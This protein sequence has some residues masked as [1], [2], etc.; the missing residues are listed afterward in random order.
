TSQLRTPPIIHAHAIPVSSFHS[1]IFLLHFILLL[2]TAL[3]LKQVPHDFLFDVFWTTPFSVAPYRYKQEVLTNCQLPTRL[4]R[5]CEGFLLR[6]H[7]H[8]A[9]KCRIHH[10]SSSNDRFFTFAMRFYWNIALFGLVLLA[11]LRATDGL[12]TVVRPNNGSFVTISTV[13]SECT[14]CEV[15]GVNATE[16]T[17][18]Q[19]RSLTP[20]QEVKLQFKCSKPIEQAF[21]VAITHTIDC[22]K[23]SCSPVSAA[24]QDLLSDLPRV[25]N[26]ELTAP[27]KTSVRLDPQGKG[28]SKT[29]KP[30][31]DG[32]LLSLSQSKSGPEELFC[33]GGPIE[34]LEVTNGA[35]VQL[36]VDP[37]TTVEPVAFTAV[38]LKGRTMEVSVGPRREVV[39]TRKPSDPECDVCTGG[40][41][42][43]TE[44]TITNADKVQLE[45]SC[46]KPQDVYTVKITENIEC[47][48]SSCTP[49]A[50]EIDL[51]LFKGFKQTLTWDISL[52]PKTVLTLDFPE[53][54]LEETSGS[55]PDGFQYFISSSKSDGTPIKSSYCRGTSLSSLYQSGQT[56]IILEVS[57][58]QDLPLTLFR[59]NAAKRGSR[60]LTVTTDPDTKVT[61]RRDPHGLDCDVCV[62]KDS[63]Q[64]CT[65]K[66][67]LRDPRNVTV[68]FSCKT[69]Q[70]YFTVEIIRDVDCAKTSCSSDI[71]QTEYSMFP[72]FNRTFI[73]DLKVVPTQAFQLNFPEPGMRQIPNKHS[74][75]DEH[76]Y[77]VVTYLR[78][79]PATIGTFCKG[80]AVSSVLVRYKGRMFLEVPGDRKLDPVDFKFSHGPQTDK[81]AILKVNLPRGVSNTTFITPNYPGDFPDEEEMQWDFVVP[82]MH[83]YSMSFSDVT[84]PECLSD[85]V[86]LEYHKTDKF[87]KFSLTD[88]QPKHQQG[89]FQMVLKNC[90]TNRTLQGLTLNFKVSVMR[91]G[92]PVLCTVDLSTQQSLSLQIEKVGSDPNC[93][94]T[95]DS[96]LQTKI[97]VASGTKGKLSFLDCPNEDLQLTTTQV[98][99]CQDYSSCPEYLLTTPKLDSCLPMPLH[100]ATWKIV[101]PEDG[102]V[103]LVSPTGTLKQSL[104]GQECR[105]PVSLHL[106]E[107]EGVSMGDFCFDGPI[108]KVQAHTNIS[109]TVKTNDLKNTRD[110]SSMCPLAQRYQRP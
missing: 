33:R 79:G 18:H 50:A 11:V 54:G 8:H 19:S 61:I 55:C 28:L 84:L 73:W 72:N 30:C 25:Y 110:T 77:S 99:E 97:N 5:G 103:D 38:P 88:P 75:P 82:G 86:I 7:R 90:A 89:N 51:D 10:F 91:S 63:K 109:I 60:M 40:D 34:V 65:H 93:E 32:V 74:C 98:I 83:N 52:P 26:W 29:K 85:D 15:T 2:P 48:E 49:D 101:M 24:A 45:F 71:L 9:L 66:Q 14:V 4:V 56:N 44:R 35:I 46:S 64:T 42:S 107:S 102:T 21:S 58:D 1:R 6:R 68:E 39:L 20:E 106:E 105:G 57:K 92:H 67:V 94:M 23:D 27:P 80:G 70:D 36:V 17:C 13:Q 78:T 69:P 16:T 76:T 22:T 43:N 100:S 87:T 96:K 108:Q 31:P 47:T 59:A 3:K 12:E 95:L 37:K 62:T 41:C 104:V 81:V 53:S